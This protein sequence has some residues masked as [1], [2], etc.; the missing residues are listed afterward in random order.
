M[1]LQCESNG[2]ALLPPVTRN[3]PEKTRFALPLAR[4]FFEDWVIKYLLERECLT[5][6][7]MEIGGSEGIR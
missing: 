3:E 5:E 7:L 4:D 2:T 1:R 6:A